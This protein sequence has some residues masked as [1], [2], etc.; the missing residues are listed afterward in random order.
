M[1]NFK[2][3]LAEVR[4]QEEDEENLFGPGS[5]IDMLVHAHNLGKD[6]S[7]EMKSLILTN[8]ES[9]KSLN[10]A[11]ANPKVEHL[12]NKRNTEWHTRHESPEGYGEI[13]G[14]PL[15]PEESVSSAHDAVT[16]H[17]K[18]SKSEQ[19]DALKTAAK[20]FGHVQYGK[21]DMTPENIVSRMASDSGNKKTGMNVDNKL[22][23]R[24]LENG[25]EATVHNNYGFGG[26]P[27]VHHQGTSSEDVSKPSAVKKCPSMTA[28]CGTGHRIKNSKGE[29]EVIPPSCLAQSGGYKFT[30]TLAKLSNNDR[31]RFG[32][33]ANPDHAIL[34]AHMIKTKAEKAKSLGKVNDH[35]FQVSDQHGDHGEA[36][37]KAVVD[38]NPH[39]KET[40]HMYDYNKDHNKVLKNLRLK[41]SGKYHMSGSFSHNG[42]SYYTDSAGTQHINNKNLMDHGKFFTALQ[43]AEKEGLDHHTYLVRGGRSQHSDGSVFSD[44][45]TG[46]THKQPKSNAADAQKKAYMDTD[47]LH[48]KTRYYGTN[49]DHGV[50]VL[51]DNEPSESHDEKTGKGH[52]S[53]M[54][55]NSEGKLERIKIPYIEHK[56]NHIEGHGKVSPDERSDGAAGG[57]GHSKSQASSAVASGAAKAI[58]G[59]NKNSLMH[60]VHDNTILDR[61][62]GVLHVANPH[63]LSK[64]GHH[65]S[66]NKV[67]NIAPAK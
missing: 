65:Y 17:Y 20:R 31:A 50:R 34:M 1:R 66:T 52:V 22:V 24:K 47:A 30:N 2:D 12:L 61:T 57:V 56:V 58:V 5:P 36:V 53:I 6:M 46:Y 55:K 18:K 9:S 13:S 11:Y 3:Y 48:T 27:V 54:Q 49:A 33:K 10:E 29:T 28:D 42:P 4:S 40:I 59:E 16:A 43:T 23:R 63:V 32:A 8:G 7:D 19:E 45:E 14:K 60:Q 44:K 39:L 62:T 51:N 37:A 41:K 64:L 15:S 26:N 25:S 21:K 38:A 35:R 67:F